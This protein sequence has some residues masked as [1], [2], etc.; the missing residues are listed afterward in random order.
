M[1]GIVTI[2][3]LMIVSDV[4]INM[5]MMIPNQLFASFTMF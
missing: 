5:R 1:N 4:I 3:T 2:P